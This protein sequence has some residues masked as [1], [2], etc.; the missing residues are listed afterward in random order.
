MLPRGCPGAPHRPRYGALFCFAS[1][2]ADAWG[3]TTDSLSGIKLVM[4][5][6]PYGRRGAV[7]L[8]V[9][10]KGLPRCREGCQHAGEY[11]CMMH[12]D[13]SP[14]LLRPRP[15]RVAP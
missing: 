12:H 5:E 11:M 13:A 14:G 3:G 2:T 1:A 15:R 4:G 7:V 8:R 6:T 9:G 10:Q